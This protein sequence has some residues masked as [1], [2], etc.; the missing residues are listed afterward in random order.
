[1]HRFIWYIHLFATNMKTLRPLVSWMLLCVPLLAQ[2]AQPGSN[3]TVLRKGSSEWGV[4]VV[5]GTGFNKRSSTQNIGIGGRW[6]H[7]WTDDMGKGWYRGNFETKTEIIP[8]QAYLQPP[9]NA[10]G[11]EMKP[12]ALIW[13]FTGNRT[14]KPFFELSGA[15]LV[16][17]RD[18]PVNTNNV[19]FTP[20]GGMGFHFF[21]KRNQ[22]LTLQG[23]YKHVSN[24]GL[25]HRN[26]GINASVQFVLGYTWFR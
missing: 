12:L 6:G 21:T 3:E 17:N 24:A 5:G 11:I 15:L 10:Y 4:F 2:S 22:A 13:N 26:S 9:E 18:V 7:V 1:M 25:D 8:F 19:N 23:M 14:V 20:Q 16:T